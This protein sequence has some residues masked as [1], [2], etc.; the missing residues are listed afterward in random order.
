[1]SEDGEK[2]CEVGACRNLFLAFFED[3]CVPLSANL[4]TL[5]VFRGVGFGA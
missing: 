4:F 5:P 1:M 2:G 3:M